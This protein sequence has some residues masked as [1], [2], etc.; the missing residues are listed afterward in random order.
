MPQLYRNTV[1]SSWRNVKFEDQDLRRKWYERNKDKIAEN[2][3]EFKKETYNTDGQFESDG[4]EALYRNSR[5]D[6]KTNR[7][8]EEYSFLKSQLTPEQKQQIYTQ[9]NGDIRSFLKD[10][11]G[12]DYV[13]NEK[14]KAREAL[15]ARD[16]KGLKSFSELM[17]MSP[18]ARE[19]VSNILN[20]RTDNSLEEDRELFSN[21][22]FAQERFNAKRQKQ[23][24]EAQQ[25]EEAGAVKGIMNGSIS[26]E[27]YD[28]I[29][30]DALPTDQLDFF[31][32][33]WDEEIYPQIRK[34]YNELAQTG[35]PNYLK[36]A[37]LVAEE[38]DNPILKAI[39]QDSK[40]YNPRRM[41][42]TPS[43]KEQR[44]IYANTALKV[45]SQLTR[46]PSSPDDFLLTG[47]S[48]QDKLSEQLESVP[49]QGREQFIK[50]YFDKEKA[51]ER[52]S[53]E[54]RKKMFRDEFL[55]KFDELYGTTPGKNKFTEAQEE[56]YE[57]L[58][59]QAG[60]NY[61][62]EEIT[63]GTIFKMNG[64][65]EIKRNL[66]DEIMGYFDKDTQVRQNFADLYA[67]EMEKKWQRDHTIVPEKK[68]E[69]KDVDTVDEFKSAIGKLS[70]VYSEWNGSNWMPLSDEDYR[71]MFQEVEPLLKKGQIDSAS[72]TI[73]DYLNDIIGEN[74][75][76]WHSDNKGHLGKVSSSL[77]QSGAMALET[78]SYYATSLPSLLWGMAEA[79][80]DPSEMQLDAG[81]NWWERSMYNTIHNDWLGVLSNS[82]IHE[83]ANDIQDN[84]EIYG[85]E[86]G[87]MFL[88]AQ[89][90]ITAS[91]TNGAGMLVDIAL[92][93]GAASLGKAALNSMTRNAVKAATRTE[94][95]KLISEGAKEQIKLYTRKIT[96]NTPLL[97]A[98]YAEAVQQ[99][100]ET[101]ETIHKQADEL[102][103]SIATQIIAEHADDFI[104]DKEN[105]F[106]YTLEDIDAA[107]MQLPKEERQRFMNAV[108]G[109]P[110]LLTQEEWDNLVIT[111]K[112]IHAF[113]T[114]VPDFDERVDAVAG[115]ESMTETQL[116]TATLF[117][118]DKML[119][120][121]D[122][123]F[124]NSALGKKMFSTKALK[125]R[126]NLSKGLGKWAAEK[127]GTKEGL[128][129]LGKA[130]FNTSKTMLS[131]TMTEVGQQ[132][133]SALGQ[134]FADNSI[135]SFLANHLYGDGSAM[136][137]DLTYDFLS[138]IDKDRFLHDAALGE[139]VKET[140]FSTF[141]TPSFGRRGKIKP[142]KRRE[143]Q[144]W[145]NNAIQ[146]VHYYNPVNLQMANEMFNDM[147]I[148]GQT[149]AFVNSINKYYNDPKNKAN[150]NGTIAAINYALEMMK[151]VITDDDFKFSNSQLS[152]NIAEAIAMSYA[153]NDAATKNHRQLIK[154]MASIKSATPE[155]QQQAVEGFRKEMKS[156]PAVEQMTDEQILDQLEEAGKR[157]DKI[158]DDV[159]AEQERLDEIYGKDRNNWQRR[160]GLIFGKLMQ[161]HLNEKLEEYQTT[162]NDIA[163]KV[164]DRDLGQTTANLS[165]IDWKQNVPKFEGTI[166]GQDILRQPPSVIAK[167]LATK[168][169]KNYSEEQQ[170]IILETN[171]ALRSVDPKQEIVDAVNNY[172]KATEQ[173]FALSREYDKLI[174]D[175]N[176]TSKKVERTSKKA[177]ENLSKNR[178]ERRFQK[179]IS[180]AKSL[181]DFRNIYNA[182]NVK[183]AERAN[184]KQFDLDKAISKLNNPQ[185]K[186]YVKQFKQVQ[187]AVNTLQQHL[188]T[189]NLDQDT[190]DLLS[191]QIEQV[192]NN[193]NNVDELLDI[194]R[195]NLP[196]DPSQKEE[197]AG[198]F[199]EILNL[200]KASSQNIQTADTTTPEDITEGK[201]LP[202]PTDLSS[203]DV[204]T[205]P[206][207]NDAPITKLSVDEAR[208][209]LNKARSIMQNP[210]GNGFSE[211]ADAMNAANQLIEEVT[212]ACPDG[213]EVVKGGSSV[214]LMQVKTDKQRIE[215]AKRNLSPEDFGNTGNQG[216]VVEGAPLN[217]GGQSIEVIEEVIPTEDVVPTDSSLDAYPDEDPRSIKKIA[218]VSFENNPVEYHYPIRD[219]DV[220]VGDNVKSKIG[221][222][223][224]HVDRV[225]T[226]E[227]Y[228]NERKQKN[229]NDEYT[230]EHI[231][232]ITAG[233]KRPEYIDRH[234]NNTQQQ[235]NEQH[236]ALEAPITE[237]YIDILTRINNAFKIR[238]WHVEDGTNVV[239]NSFLEGLQDY[240]K[241]NV[242]PDK[243]SPYHNMS[244]ADFVDKYFEIIN[245]WLNLGQIL[246]AK[247]KSA[248]EA[249]KITPSVAE[250]LAMAGSLNTVGEI[251]ANLKQFDSNPSG[252][253][254]KHPTA[255]Q[256]TTP[257]T[258]TESQ[259]ERLNN[260][261]TPARSE[262]SPEFM[263]MSADYKAKEDDK[264]VARL[265][266]KEHINI[267]SQLEANGAFEYCDNGSLQVGDEIKFVVTQEAM[268]DGSTSVVIWEVTEPKAQIEG[269][270]T[271]F[272][273]KQVLS[274]LDQT[275]AGGDRAELI[276][277]IR[278]AYEEAGRPESFLYDKETFKV[279]EVTS[280]IVPFK[281]TNP[282]EA[283]SQETI[284][285]NN[286]KKGLQKE[287]GHYGIRFYKAST[288]QYIN[289]RIALQQE[290]KDNSG[291]TVTLKTNDYITSVTQKTQMGISGTNEVMLC[292]P[293]PKGYQAVH[294]VYVMRRSIEGAI[295]KYKEAIQNGQLGKKLIEKIAPR[296]QDSKHITAFSDYLRFAPNVSESIVFYPSNQR[297]ELGFSNNNVKTTLITAIRKDN[298]WYIVDYKDARNVLD[299]NGGKGYEFDEL[300]KK[301]LNELIDNETAGASVQINMQAIRDNQDILDDLIDDGFLWAP[302]AIDARFGMENVG[303]SAPISEKTKPTVKPQAEPTAQP[304]QQTPTQQTQPVAPEVT[305][306]AQTSQPT[307]TTATTE[308]ATPSSS[309]D[310]SLGN[311]VKRRKKRASDIKPEDVKVTETTPNV[312]PSK[313]DEV[314]GQPTVQA[315]DYENLPESVKQQ[316]QE[317]GLTQQEFD[318]LSQQEKENVLNCIS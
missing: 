301:Y 200:A 223:Q 82:S 157:V 309:N 288:G 54:S 116:A 80:V 231:A 202:A 123:N 264:K 241:Y 187:A 315:T 230:V 177:K 92:T 36:A 158:Y 65:P 251:K 144:S 101:E 276:A 227:E 268:P 218:V 119:G 188:Q 275:N 96:E 48:L 86:F 317:K 97:K 153:P 59:F 277:R 67:E 44:S 297:I 21:S 12:D 124:L 229:I 58:A 43:D 41:S 132:S 85:D 211:Y 87:A 52:L 262:I 248:T 45:L 298:K 222:S 292:V 100:I 134:Q 91:V 291:N 193:V 226:V 40:F 283:S 242:L 165:E 289:A 253:T 94:A 224:G 244:E 207:V 95:K 152:K 133:Y 149:D 286:L 154:N 25:E 105:R 295:E 260:N 166:S 138:E 57:P 270:D 307:E 88:R 287:N 62:D 284:V 77:R 71:N 74:Q 110:G 164:A 216:E 176:W 199:Q 269:A 245:R 42:G 103:K 235:T 233:S 122:K 173:A 73:D 318:A 22:Q 128:K 49:L 313:I 192:A 305:P 300:C 147:A 7:A 217:L 29:M 84:A 195:Y 252:K 208:K 180:R 257:S 179:N 81:Y 19:E 75:E 159:F 2:F 293:T 258:R 285:S 140:L 296:V 126:L 259:Q 302:N 114:L 204:D 255:E 308:T 210:A 20:N 137:G 169:F 228:E 203:R 249:F 221:G 135:E 107:I 156:N 17:G 35:D 274:V 212:K 118:A 56:G 299:N 311:K 198:K 197:V 201:P 247:G 106:P 312:Q 190:K 109:D 282:T 143:D 117:L 8:G 34:K 13:N 191:D 46:T 37:S 178:K 11:Y 174:A 278:N 60:T 112:A 185:V 130:A 184:D 26:K 72:W 63:A 30:K 47:K 93:R 239:I 53:P 266:N 254:V 246:I 141:I 27:E 232:E 121:I 66:W 265:S 186:E 32:K 115:L 10:V 150:V 5:F 131:E 263:P 183:N 162:I 113:N 310:L 189:L 161:Q 243:N 219:E 256:I 23:L 304:Q 18:T 171:Q 237:R 104:N 213:Y 78:A 279:K 61:F 142:T 83:L 15:L 99:G 9:Y 175:E 69:F 220:R 306:M 214:A 206:P 267:D 281:A 160:S 209:K 151:A 167:L 129:S 196:V 125:D 3:P 24:A 39:I 139:T 168:N 145:L 181:S 102:K 1:K 70:P 225:I 240:Y 31:K 51:K 234:T 250:A 120:G 68:N 238:R 89:P 16:F 273:G 280:G 205:A 290:R 155:E 136:V 28:K 236:S 148:A 33:Q 6:E 38:T 163:D 170:K 172:N 64:L 316:I 303:F 108:N 111:A 4:L 50:D 314:K 271:K 14:L 194:S 146:Q 294:S 90:S 79:I 127:F 215:E 272:Q 261:I 182:E 55:S 76:Y 98:N